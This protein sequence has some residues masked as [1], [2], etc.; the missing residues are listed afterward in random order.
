MTDA[1][2]SRYRV[3]ERGRRLVVID[4]HSGRPVNHEHPVVAAEPNA[5]RSKPALPTMQPKP[6]GVPGLTMDERGKQVITTSRLI[7]DK[8]PRRITVTGDAERLF[9][10]LTSMA[11]GG[12]VV[13]VVLAILFWPVVFAPFALAYQPVRAAA[14]RA[15]TGWF[16]RMVQAGSSTG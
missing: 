2:P 6:G 12:V 1:P 15:L 9:G 4:N 3:V 16:D 5:D 7:D 8:G 13:F 10:N 14:R 11:L